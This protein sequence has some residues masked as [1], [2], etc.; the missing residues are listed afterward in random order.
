VVV[1]DIFT[2]AAEELRTILL[3]ERRRS[4]RVE[5]GFLEA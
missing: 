5:L 4:S 3:A 1:N 2:R